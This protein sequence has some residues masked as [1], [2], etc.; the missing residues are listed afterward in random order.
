MMEPAENPILKWAVDIIAHAPPMQ[1]VVAF[2]IVL[3]LA[4]PLIRAGLKELRSDRRADSMTRPTTSVP[5]QIESPWLVQHLVEMHLAIEDIKKGVDAANAKAD[6]NAASLASIA[7]LLR[8]R[9]NRRQA[10]T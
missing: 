5:V 4:L 10:K 9:A 1:N 2:I 6:T 7:K 8:Q 3:L